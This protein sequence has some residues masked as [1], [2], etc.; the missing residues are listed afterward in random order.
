[1]EDKNLLLKQCLRDMEEELGHREERLRKMVASREQVQ[2]ELEKY[3]RECEKLD[4]DLGVAIDKDKDVIARLLIKKLKPLALH[5]EELGRHIATLD[6][7]IR[8][9]RDCVEKQRLQYEQLQLRSKE[10]FRRAEREQWERRI[11]SII[12]PGVMRE[13]SEEEVELEL[14]QLKEAGRGGEKG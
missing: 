3:S 4:E 14:L 6:Q 12:P 10:H 7:E 1:M 2:R 9:F 11:S 13:P 5:R 8:Q